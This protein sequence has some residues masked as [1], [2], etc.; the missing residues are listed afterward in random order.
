MFLFPFNECVNN[1]L[2]TMDIINI[3]INQGEYTTEELID[4]ITRSLHTENKCFW[5]LSHSENI[6][7]FHC[8][9]RFL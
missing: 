4:Y 9:Q 6:Y 5:G 7:T 3:V 2:S 1:S 8:S